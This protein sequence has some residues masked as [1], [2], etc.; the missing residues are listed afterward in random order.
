M[1]DWSC[2]E[3]SDR[4]SF[5]ASKQFRLSPYQCQRHFI[6]IKTDLLS[7]MFTKTIHILVQNSTYE[8]IHFKRI[9][10]CPQPFSP[11]HPFFSNSSDNAAK[12]EANGHHV[13]RIKDKESYLCLSVWLKTWR[14]NANKAGADRKPSFYLVTPWRASIMKQTF[15]QQIHVLNGLI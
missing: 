9:S 2:L 10:E 6:I 15:P 12:K 13:R 5:T 14:V 8:V 11:S 4:W 7:S 3:Y 1:T